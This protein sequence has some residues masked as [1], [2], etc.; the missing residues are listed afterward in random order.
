SARC[1][2]A[3][4]VNPIGS[5][6]KGRSAT[7][8]QQSTGPTENNISRLVST[9]ICS[10]TV[11]GGGVSAFE[12]AGH[13]SGGSHAICMLLAAGYGYKDVALTDTTGTI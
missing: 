7:G 5:P 1:V 6:G 8:K 13:D 4:G 2:L 3:P 10:P 9:G 11:V 12:K